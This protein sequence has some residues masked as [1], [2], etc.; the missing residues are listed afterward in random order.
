MLIGVDEVGR[1]CWA[2][3]VVAGAVA[4]M[5][6]I[7]GLKDSKLLTRKQREYLAGQIKSHS[8][9]GTGWAKASEV[10][11]IGLTLAVKLAMQR[12]IDYWADLT[13]V[14]QIIIDGNYNFLDNLPR[15]KCMIKADQKVPEVSAASILAKVARDDYMRQQALVFPGYGF[16][17]HV[18]YGTA[19]HKE[20]LKQ[21][22]VCELHRKSYK[23][24]KQM[25]L[26]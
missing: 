11:E 12:A 6:P 17:A 23:P 18:G 25:G 24:I 20:R 22:G 2:G 5:Q 9:W 3:P 14:K 16:D 7:D 26:V 1:G 13:N 10:D 21:Y 4:L 15:V 8:I 19:L